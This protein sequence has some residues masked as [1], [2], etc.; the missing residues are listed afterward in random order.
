MSMFSRPRQKESKDPTS[1][2]TDLVSVPTKL[3]EEDCEDS[4]RDGSFVLTK[5]S[6]VS[7]DVR[8]KKH[9]IPPLLRR[10]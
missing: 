3:P 10:P 7:A 6:P 9:P 2:A 4:E 5:F 1:I 8:R